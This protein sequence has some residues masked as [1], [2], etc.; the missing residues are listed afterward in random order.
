MN[1]LNSAAYWSSFADDDFAISEVPE[2]QFEQQQLKNE[3]LQILKFTWF[4]E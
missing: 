2:L 4:L 1:Y 3:L